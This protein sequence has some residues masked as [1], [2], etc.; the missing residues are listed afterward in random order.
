MEAYAYLMLV[1]IA[2]ELCCCIWL[3]HSFAA[4]RRR[5]NRLTAAADIVAIL[6]AEWVVCDMLFYDNLALKAVAV[7]G[8]L[9]LFMY[10]WFQIRYTKAAVLVMLFYSLMLVADYMALVVVGTVFPGKMW[11][12]SNF[13]IIYGLRIASLA[14]E[15]GMVFAVKKMLGSKTTDLFTVREWYALAAVSLITIFS[16]ISITME[17]DWTK[18]TSQPIAV[19]FFHIHIIGGIL[20]INFIGFYLI[21]SI[22]E[23]ELKLREYAVF[24][25]K[26]NNETAMYRSISENLEKQ[27]KRTHEYKNQLAAISALAAQGAWQELRDYIE[28]I[29]TTLQHRMDAVDTNHVIVNAILNTKYREA[30]NK[31]IVFVLKVNDLSALK[32]KDEDIVVILSN[33]LNNALEACEQC[34][35]KQ[36]KLKFVLENGQAVISVKNSMAA[37]PLVENG[38]I[39]SSK[40]KD[41]AEH[42][43]GIQNVAETVEKYGGRYMVDY[44][45]GEFQF[46]ILIPNNQAKEDKKWQL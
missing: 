20:C 11:D 5:K 12:L 28:Q 42:G 34:E 35:T 24:R 7:I 17:T 16:V 39:L 8:L 6:A 19:D 4:K 14:L 41:A 27:R 38:K 46:S 40:T 31:G 15:F 3:F 43:M 23:R 33:L 25:E 32:I 13:F 26:V 9:S 2:L 18:Y 30:V 36:I 45:E 44:G 1:F 22:T 10:R 21:H 37:E 29:E